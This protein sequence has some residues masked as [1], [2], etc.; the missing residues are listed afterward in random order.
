MQD[1]REREGHKK[2]THTIPMLYTGPY[3]T[4]LYMGCGDQP[5]CLGIGGS[6]PWEACDHEV[7]KHLLAIL[8]GSEAREGQQW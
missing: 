7:A 2:N 8:E 4:Y 5:C 1:E 3:C 6:F